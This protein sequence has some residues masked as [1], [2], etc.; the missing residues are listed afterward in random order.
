MEETMRYHFWPLK[1]EKVKSLV[2]GREK[3][4]KNSYALF[5][6]IEI[7]TIFLEGALLVCR[8]MQTFG[9]EFALLGIYPEAIL[10]SCAEMY[11]AKANLLN[12]LSICISLLQQSHV[13]DTLII[14][15]LKWGKWGSEKLN[16]VSGKAKF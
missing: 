10:D 4:T 6:G 11:P 3:R 8:T 2:L 5:E 16:I 12:I 9:P 1:F 14:P 15:I 13:V 7:G